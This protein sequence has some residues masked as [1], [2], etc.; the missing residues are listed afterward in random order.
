MSI[1]EFVGGMFMSQYGPDLFSSD[2]GI[3]MRD[4]YKNLSSFGINHDEIIVLFKKFFLGSKPTKNEQNLFW[5]IMARIQINYGVLCSEVKNEALKVIA[6]GE[7]IQQWED[8][9]NNEKYLFSSPSL[10]QE[11]IDEMSKMYNPNESF[12]D[13]VLKMLEHMTNSKK[14]QVDDNEALP[15]EIHLQERSYDFSK[16]R[17][18]SPDGKKYHKKRIQVIEKLKDDIENFVYKPKKLTINVDFAP[19]WKIGD[20]YAM[21]L[22]NLEKGYYKNSLVGEIGKYIVFEV[23]GINHRP[24]SKVLT[25]RGHHI[26]IFIQPF[27]YLENSIPTLE[28]LA[29]LDYLPKENA[30]LFLPKPLEPEYIV[31]KPQILEVSFYR[32]ARIF[33]NLKLI[34]LKEGTIDFSKTLINKSGSLLVFISSIQSDIAFKIKKYLESINLT[35]SS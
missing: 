21:Q 8:Y 17:V 3:T 30:S 18:F 35:K 16:I 9:A 2:I 13:N 33:K 32:S 31:R 7:D 15:D 23:S 22:E 14:A 4:E 12:D 24:I 11:H 20:I 29:Q 34:K 25:N 26:E 6:S 10:S 1:M 5:L 27:L 28:T 19:K